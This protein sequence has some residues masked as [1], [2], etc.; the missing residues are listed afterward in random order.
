MPI[1]SFWSTV[2]STQTATTST[3]VAASCA[4]TLRNNYKVLVTQTNYSNLDLES[5]FV[6]IDKMTS[7]GDMDIADIGM[8]ALDRLLRSNKLTPENMPNYVKPIYPGIKN[9][10]ELLYGTFKNDMDSYSRVLET[11]P[12]IIEQASKYYD[13][14]FVD[15]SKGIN[16]TEINKILQMSDLI[17]LSLSQDMQILK[18]IFKSMDTFKILQE[19][20]VIPVIG[21]YDRYSKYN[22]KNIA[23]YFNYKKNI[24]TIPYNTQFFDSCN[25]GKAMNF[26][27]ENIKADMGVDRNG[28]FISEASK[29]ADAI[30]DAIKAKLN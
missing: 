22:N 10:L 26:Y 7:K 3:I 29:L 21:K 11:M 1:V 17:V 12:I 18:K 25:E 24:Y 16:N 8:D 20:T 4:T 27:I 5:S 6:N 9:R 13:I 30:V 19:K 15:L 28:F 23:R 2:E 14:V